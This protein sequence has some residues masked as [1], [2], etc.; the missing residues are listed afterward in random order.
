VTA[1]MGG[2]AVELFSSGA[3]KED[4]IMMLKPEFDTGDKSK[5]V[6]PGIPP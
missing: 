6:H 3:R 1:M 2:E 5:G 4:S